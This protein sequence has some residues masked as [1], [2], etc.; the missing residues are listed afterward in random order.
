[1]FVQGLT[2]DDLFSSLFMGGSC[3][4]SRVFWTGFMFNHFQRIRDRPA[5]IADGEANKFAAWVNCKDS[6]KS[7]IVVRKIWYS[8]LYTQ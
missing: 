4:G 8:T 3:D 7:F 2:D 6:H 5:R 1:M